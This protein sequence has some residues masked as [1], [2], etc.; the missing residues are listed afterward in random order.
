MFVFIWKHYPE[1]FAFL[2][3]RILES[4]THEVCKQIV[5]ECFLTNFSHISNAH[6]SRRKRCFN[7]KSST[8]YFHVKTKILADF[9]FCISVSLTYF[10][11]NVSILYCLKTP[12][13]PRF[14]G[15]STI[16]WKVSV[17]GVALVRIFRH[18]GWIRR[19]IPFL[20]IFPYSVRMRENMDQNNSE[21]GHFLRSLVVVK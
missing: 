20:C 19:D 21:Y 3:L 2:I 16:A 14:P 8:Y 5:S 11:T 6:I 1:N 7:V 10:F 17:F 12:E 4:F 15:V 9:Q 13:I 18:L